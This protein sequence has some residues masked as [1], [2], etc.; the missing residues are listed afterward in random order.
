MSLAQRVARFS[1]AP[2][3]YADLA[4]NQPYIVSEYVPGPSLKDLVEQEGPRRG[5]ALERLGLATATA[6][7]AIHQAGITHRDLKPANVLMGPEGPVVIDFGVA[8]ALDAPQATMSGTTMGTP[9]T[10]PPSC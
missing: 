10:W 7:S 4:G 2:V 9:P 6:L 3:L 8:K 1:T 5:A